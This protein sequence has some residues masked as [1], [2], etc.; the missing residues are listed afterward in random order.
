M[1]VDGEKKRRR[2]S[3]AVRRC[4]V[5]GCVLRLV[6]RAS[7]PNDAKALA[8]DFSPRAAAG[9]MCMWCPWPSTREPRREQTV[10]QRCIVL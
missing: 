1:V 5:G 6:W 8:G 7:L 2:E 10:S 4:W 3:E 9:A